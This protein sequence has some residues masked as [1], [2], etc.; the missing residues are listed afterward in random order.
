MAHKSVSLTAPAPRAVALPARSSLSGG[1]LILALLLAVALGLL[2]LTPPA[3]APKNAPATAFSAERAMEHLRVIAS[4]PHPIGSPAHAE[5]RDYLV[6]QLRELGLEPQLQ[7]A[8]AVQERYGVQVGTVQNVVARIAGAES[9]QAIMLAAHYD[10]VPTSPGA[11][12]D[13]AAVAAILETARALTAGEPLQRDVILLFTDGEEAGLLGAR[14]FVD[15]HPWAKD[16]GLVLNFEARGSSGPAVMFETSAGNRELLAALA[17]ASPRPVAYSF[18]YSIYRMMPNGSDL[19]VFKELG[20]QGLNFGFLF[21]WPDYHSMR[22]S[23]ENIDP[24]SLQHHGSYM[25]AL[26]RHYGNSSLGQASAGDAIFFTLWPGLL[27]QYPEGW[28]LPL[29]AI[30]ALLFV[31]AVVTGLRRKRLTIAGLAGGFLAFLLSVVAALLAVTLAWLAIQQLNANYRVFLM[32]TTYEAGLYL[33]AFVAL[34]VAVMA[35]LAAL[36]LRKLRAENLAMGALGVWTALML[37]SSVALPGVSYLF[38]WPLLAALLAALWRL[39]ND[40]DRA[41]PRSRAAALALAAVPGLL[42]LTPAAYLLF[43]LLGLSVAGASLIL[44][45]LLC[46]LLLPHLA[47]LPGRA[48]ALLPAGALLLS[49]GLIVAAN[50]QSGFDTEHPRP[51]SILYSLDADTGR[52]AWISLGEAPDAWTA[53]FLGS[54]PERQPF[55]IVPGMTLPALSAEAPAV[56]LA[57]PEVELLEDTTESGAR[58]LRLLVTSPRR[59]WSTSIVART[60]SGIRA[61]TVAGRRFELADRPLSERTTW[62]M[63]YLA[64]SEQGVELT[65]ELEPDAQLALVVSDTVHGLPEIPGLPIGP[66]PADMMPAPLD[67]TDSTQVT[68]SFDY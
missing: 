43:A 34:V 52:A 24:R 33:I 40:A 18:L 56:A 20:A 17:E 5:V 36:L 28:A 68:R 4:E 14:A 44:V 13:G 15:E 19:T 46:G 66:R 30:V 35:G 27:V 32:G 62:A 41:A 48:R 1:L 11:S 31:V 51:S 38:T 10:S 54:Q 60:E 57:A 42:L 61:V 47:A 55:E 39:A 9:G 37:L 58:R 50:L 8:T 3:V 65:I 12:D 49:A 64:L 53:Q 2:Q 22:D 26:T 63:N 59:P 45:P 6:A 29:A 25:L 67:M 23:V 7:T 21:D 16:V